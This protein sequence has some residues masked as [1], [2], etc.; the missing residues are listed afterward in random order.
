MELTKLR[1]LGVACPQWLMP[2]VVAE[3]AGAEGQL[4]FRVAAELP[5]VGIVASYCGYLNLNV[6]RPS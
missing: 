3:E 1:F 5:L 6:E 2:H 4:H